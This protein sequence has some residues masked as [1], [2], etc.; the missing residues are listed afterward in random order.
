M[1]LAAHAYFPTGNHMTITL[2]TSG[3]EGVVK[4]M[5]NL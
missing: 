1:Q 4:L 3:S 2:M 5:F